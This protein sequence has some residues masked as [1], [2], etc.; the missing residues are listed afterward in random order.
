[1]K[2]F[3]LSFPLTKPL[4]KNETRRY[5]TL[6]WCALI[7]IL[8]VG[9]G[10]RFN[11][12]NWDES[13]SLH[14]DER[15][16]IFQ[17]N[18]GGVMNLMTA[19]T[20]GDCPNVETP[21][22]NIDFPPG[23]LSF[24]WPNKYMHLTSV[25]CGQPVPAEAINFWNATYSP[26]N[27]H[28]FAYGSLP[29]YLIKLTAH[30]YSAV[31]GKD[32]TGYNPLFLVGRFLSVLFSLGT[33][34]L[35]FGIGR[36]AF[37]PALGQREGDA[38]GLLAAAFLS[39]SAL[40]IQLAH[41][42]AFDEP[43]TFFVTLT[44]FVAI[45][46]MRNGSR[47]G[48]M[49]LGFALGL[50]LATKF[51]SAP[52]A[53]PAGLAILLYGL[54]GNAK[55][56]GER[57][58]KPAFAPWPNETRYK[59][60][61]LGPRLIFRTLVNLLIMSISTLAAWFVGMPYAF[62]D[63]KNYSNRLIEE[64]GMA[65]GIDSIPYTRQFVGS[66]P[67]LYQFENII[68][69]GVGLPLGIL[70]VGA[71]FYTLWCSVSTRL[72][73]DFILWAWILPYSVSIFSFEAK[74]IR[75]NLPLIP[76]LIILASRMIV[77]MVARLRRG[78]RIFGWSDLGAESSQLSANSYQSAA[79][80]QQPQVITNDF[81]LRGSS[82]EPET[83]TNSY[84]SSAISPQPVIASGNAHINEDN[85]LIAFSHEQAV[86]EGQQPQIASDA[87]QKV[88][89][90]EQAAVSYQSPVFNQQPE[91]ATNSFEQIRQ[92]N[93]PTA[94]SP[95]QSVEKSQPS[96]TADDFTPVALNPLP[97]AYRALPLVRSSHKWG[98]R[99]VTAIGLFTFVWSAVWAI[100]FEH[101]YGQTHT[102]IQA[103]N[104][105][106]QNVPAGASVSNE[107]WDE[108][109]P[110]PVSG[111]RPD[112]YK[113][114]G[115]DIYND[116]PPAET[117]DYFVKQIEQTDY[118]VEAS[119]RLYATM[120]K[121]PWRYP[122]Q[123]RYYELLF[124][125]NLGYTLAATFTEY[126]TVPFLNWQINDDHAD[127]SFTVY[128]H[129]KVYIFKKT[130][131]LSDAE[132]HGLFEA[133]TQAPWVVMR[134]PK[135]SD[136]PK[137]QASEGDG[138]LISSTAGQVNYDG[139]SLLLDKPVDQLPVIDDIGWNKPA[140]D[141][142]WFGVILW[143]VLA[144][145]LGLVGLP[146]AMRVGSRLPDKGYI[147]AKPIGAAVM[148]LVIWLIVSSRVLMNTV[149]TNYL[150]LGLSIVFSG[151]LWWRY[152]DEMA[153]F[154]QQ[155]RKIIIIEE[156]LFL[157]V[158]AIL[159]GLR[160]GNPD[161]WHPTQGG[162]KPM[163][164]THVNAL[165]KS[166]YFPPYDPWFSDGYVNYYYYGQYIFTT[167]MKLTGIRPGIAFNLAVPMVGTFTATAAF[168]LVL[169]LV[170]LHEQR[171]ARLANETYHKISWRK[172]VVSGLFGSLMLAG[173]GNLDSLAQIFQGQK[174]VVDFA[175]KLNL[176]P[177]EP[178]QQVKIFD[179]WRSSRV[180][181]YTINEFP[182]F[183]SIYAD[184]HANIIALSFT[185]VILGIA[186]NLIATNWLGYDEKGQNFW[187]RA[188]SRVW[189]VFDGTLVT[190]LILAVLIGLL[191]AT[192]TW[193]VPTYLA[194]IAVAFFLALFRRPKQPLYR[195]TQELLQ[196][197]KFR[198]GSLVMDAGLAVA[199][200]VG[201]LVVGVALY[202]NF[203]SHFLAL[204]SSISFTASPDSAHIINYPDFSP[205]TELLYFVVLFGIFL[206]FIA[207]YIIWNLWDWSRLSAPSLQPDDSDWQTFEEV[208][209]TIDIDHEVTPVDAVE[210]VTSQVFA[211]LRPS[212]RRFKLTPPRPNVAFAMAGADGGFNMGGSDGGGSDWNSNPGW[213]GWQPPASNFTPASRR[214]RFALPWLIG[215][216]LLLLLA[217]GYT[218]INYTWGLLALLIPV[219]AGLIVLLAVRPFDPDPQQAAA[220]RSAP[221]M[222]VKLLLL[223]G[224]GIVAMCEVLYLADDLNNYIYERMNMIF[225]F[226]YQVWTLFAIAA[227]FGG[228]IFWIKVIAPRLPALSM[229]NLADFKPSYG[230]P[231]RNAGRFGWIGAAVI[232]LGIGVL[233]PLLGTPT[234]WS[235]RDAQS[236]DRY[237]YPP[238]N[239]G[240]IPF[241]LDGQAYLSE[242]HCVV[243]M[244]N[245]E[246]GLHFD[247]KY[248]A[249][250]INEFYN[251]VSGT[252][253][254]LQ[255]SIAPYRGGGSMVTINTG[256]PT[257]LGWDHHE[258]QQRYIS[259]IYQRSF[260][261]R[262]QNTGDIREIY[263]TDDI[264]RALQLLNHYHV[265]YVHLGVVERAAE[266]EGPPT[267]EGVRQYDQFMSDVGYAK[268]DT[269]VK[270][271]LLD[272][273]YQNQGV[274]VY[275]LTTRGLSGVIQSVPGVDIGSTVNV[276]LQRLLDS[277]KREP[278]NV[279]NRNALA[280]Y[281]LTTKDY[282][283]A[284]EQLAAVIKLTPQQV[285][286]YQVLGDAYDAMGKSDLALETFRQAE[287]I[288]PN[289]PA[290]WNKV[291]LALLKRNQLD[292][293]LTQFQQEAKISPSFE[294][295]YYQQGQVY[296]KMGKTDQAI[297]VYRQVAVKAES[298]SSAWIGLAQQRL[299]A[300]GAK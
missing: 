232:L 218:F 96:A 235:E 104:W 202:W 216:G 294:E 268:F 124:N 231:Y 72:K 62:L 36:R 243:G 263:T 293:A 80:S 10:L 95:A 25:A 230:D 149:G 161:L 66:T 121:L 123:N 174:S 4:L 219:I 238:A 38:I 5:A 26:L 179:Y 298:P 185:L 164:L 205:H 70:I 272:V 221:D 284:V 201:V 220:A 261:D 32:Y 54:Y 282:A 50:A 57:A 228:Y 269:M 150:G 45:G 63:F 224:C 30:V 281:Y 143:L 58:T 157:V 241:G 215:L 266:V 88:I 154:F 107:M 49:R 199:L 229:P 226:Y 133:S 34:L 190:P 11:K 129:P 33:I 115:Y 177:G 105:I 51:S 22:Q 295:A 103:S 41:F 196:R 128:D 297:Q 8:I 244:T 213:S 78:Q 158:F 223:A 20:T 234:K 47:W 271:G 39:V 198:F 180:V 155:R 296:E 248:D 186:L 91:T 135:P 217:A 203:Y 15:A 9:A 249:Q 116:R 156:I 1:M 117:A 98:A 77:E 173:I 137:Q 3:L 162:E 182:M 132:L 130:Q 253:I 210:P 16:I 183:D 172:P 277:V 163:E 146:L 65:R 83:V 42:L 167:W 176:Y 87:G 279:S 110:M 7:L 242:L 125:G 240:N 159:I 75:Y 245:M 274:A 122:V 168:S 61:A 112:E 276:K 291:G 153:L 214:N 64:G 151:W 99:I 278:D 189:K 246:P 28:F 227:A 43:L 59:R 160:L 37:G 145:I 147:L 204:Y 102:R 85:Q 27:P 233:Y 18:G 142:Q 166:A 286:A 127:E 68:L 211:N 258:T 148:A 197:P 200:M 239:T 283:K 252:P 73:A 6:V 207:S 31:T 225:K 195:D 86:D 69:W 175:Q 290:S 14:P 193:D 119:N 108:S 188:R 60:V 114:I 191:G 287:Q 144:Q 181:P 23:G 262:G 136:L 134:H 273:A 264:N 44:V 84:L 259:Q 55:F 113:Q 251:H 178:V 275:K 257:V 100:S 71:L 289:E 101:I 208:E 141:Q 209:P 288:A 74:F 139:K 255:A 118:I 270:L 292:A 13:Q 48:A 92:N 254:V 24:F 97:V 90:E 206:F 46:Q 17:G 19:A 140:N 53:I 169:N 250:A 126:P 79:I 56:S 265:T 2:N 171:L 21:R 131:T 300:L 12:L 260:I 93:Q 212:L 236:N 81:E 120:P 237:C 111:H 267:K 256:L 82:F 247:F 40:D 76:F 184:F 194:I 67:V 52:V 280:Q 285:N 187:R 109:L 138:A 222:L 165:L 29:M 192:N 106:Y 35:V 94:F 299:T 152:R 89:H 170:G